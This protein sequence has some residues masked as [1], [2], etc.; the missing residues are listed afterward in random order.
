ME[1]FK[2]QVVCVNSVKRI[3]DPKLKGADHRS[4]PAAANILGTYLDEQG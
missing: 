4:A 1:N 3:A 2:H